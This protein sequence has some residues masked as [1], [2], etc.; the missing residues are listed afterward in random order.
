MTMQELM[1]LQHLNREIQ[2]IEERIEEIRTRAEHI[3]PNVQTFKNEKGEICVLPNT[4]GGGAGDK[5]LNDVCALMKEEEALE[6]AKIKRSEEKQKLWNYINEI[7]SSH[8]RQIFI[9]RFLNGYSW[10]KVAMRIGGGNS[11]DGVK[12]QVYR[13]LE[14]Q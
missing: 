7:Q 2:M 12:K 10:T 11:A 9:L 4:H 8:L 14:R 5:M 13:F 3:T 1:N 6:A